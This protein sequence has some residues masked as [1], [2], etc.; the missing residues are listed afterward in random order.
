MFFALWFM[1]MITV[2]YAPNL[3]KMQIGEEF[4]EKQQIELK[5]EIEGKYKLEIEYKDGIRIG[6]IDPSYL[7]PG[8]ASGVTIFFLNRLYHWWKS[9]KSK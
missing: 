2:V 3:Q 1:L 7:L 5:I 9:R 4:P 6:T 8:I